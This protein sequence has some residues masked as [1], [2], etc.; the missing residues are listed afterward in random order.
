MVHSEKHF[1]LNALLFIFCTCICF[2]EE[3][4]I[5]KSLKNTTTVI[6]IKY[7]LYMIIANLYYCH[8]KSDLQSPV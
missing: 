1:I 8:L 7:K 3:E 4:K 6:Y 5:F 2:K